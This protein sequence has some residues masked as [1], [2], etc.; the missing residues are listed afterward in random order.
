MTILMKADAMKS[1]A[2]ETP[3]SLRDISYNDYSCTKNTSSKLQPHK[4][5]SDDFREDEDLVDDLNTRTNPLRFKN[6]LNEDNRNEDYR[7][8]AHIDKD[9]RETRP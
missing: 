9:H 3:M 5:L 2:T 7:D 6:A 4:D 8:E 1:Q